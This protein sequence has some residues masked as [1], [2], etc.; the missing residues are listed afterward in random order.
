MLIIDNPTF[1]PLYYL[2]WIILNITQLFYLNF[3]LFWF[4]FICTFKFFEIS[5]D[6]RIVNGVNRNSGIV[7]T[8]SS[9][10]NKVPSNSEKQIQAKQINNSM[11]TRCWN[12][13]F[14][15]NSASIE[16]SKSFSA[17]HLRSRCR[18]RDRLSHFQMFAKTTAHLDPNSFRNQGESW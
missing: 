4:S 8:A 7:I 1:V 13:I 6:S 16:Q 2:R 3:N 15:H 11:F 14:G 9:S 10:S 5:K 17:R 12:G 18:Q